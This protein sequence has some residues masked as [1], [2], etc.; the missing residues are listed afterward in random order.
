MDGVV[1]MLTCRVEKDWWIYFCFLNTPYRSMFR[2]AMATIMSDSVRLYC[3]PISKRLHLASTSADEAECDENEVSGVPRAREC[4]RSIATQTH[5]TNTEWCTDGYRLSM[6]RC[7]LVINS[8][9]SNTIR[10]LSC[11][12]K[13]VSPCLCILCTRVSS[14]ICVAASS[15]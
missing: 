8:S 5:H 14:I 4:R 12:T 1:C 3:E 7:L 10:P 6:A 13:P 2:V 15:V 11:L 9:H